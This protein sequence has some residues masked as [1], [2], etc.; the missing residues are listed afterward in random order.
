MRRAPFHH[1]ALIVD[2]DETL[3]DRLA[4]LI[5]RGMVAHEP[6]LM[7]VTARTEG[8]I[9]GILGLTATRVVWGDSS[10]FYRS[11]GT[12]YEMFRRYLVRQHRNGQRVH[13]VAEPSFDR[14]DLPVAVSRVSEYLAYE[15]VCNQ[16][17]APYGCPVTCLWDSRSQSPSVIDQVRGLHPYEIGPYGRTRQPRFVS[18]EAYLRERANRGLGAVPEANDLDIFPTEDMAPVRA[19]VNAWAFS[20]GFDEAM[21]GD[22]VVAVSEIIANA[23][24]HG[25][26]PVRLRCWRDGG[27]LVAQVDDAGGAPI[28]SEAGYIPPDNISPGGRG[29]W[30]ARQL[31][32]VVLTSSQNG[33]TS[34]RLH[35]PYAV[36]VA[37]HD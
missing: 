11:L 3:R 6:M 30:L 16:V 25:S 32:D 1:S 10:G 37:N 19:A 15:A 17:Y 4:P 2:S 26:A 14:T 24:V 18:S 27:T 29:L 13:V 34:V 31:A 22:V 36:T 9:R 8:I 23:F 12:A 20:A 28:P 7:V 5:E 21:A 35:F 33:V